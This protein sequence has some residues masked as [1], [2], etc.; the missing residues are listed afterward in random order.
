MLR[1]LFELVV[2]TCEVAAEE[3]VVKEAEQTVLDIQRE[4]IAMLAAYDAPTIPTVP[5]FAR[6]AGKSRVK[7][8]DWQLDPVRLAQT[9]AVLATAKGHHRS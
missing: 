4:R 1:S 8:T 2:A 6:L 3:G 9:Q 7:G 5:A